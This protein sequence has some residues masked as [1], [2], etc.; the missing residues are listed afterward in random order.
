MIDKKNLNNNNNN[1]NN[2]NKKFQNFSPKKNKP[3]ESFLAL[4]EYKKYC[5]KINSNTNSNFSN[6][7]RSESLKIFLF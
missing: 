1:N 3:K 6:Q 7:I 4:E 5:L 2:N